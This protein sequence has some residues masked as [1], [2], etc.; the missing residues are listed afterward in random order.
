MQP[1]I[2]IALLLLPLLWKTRARVPML[3]CLI[4]FI[5][6]WIHMALAAG[7]TGA[8]HAILPWPLPAMF[9]AVAFAEASRHISFG[10]W[11]LGV[12]MIV[13]AVSGLLV[14][15][16]HLYQLAR[17]GAGDPW[18]DAIYPLAGGLKKTN[19]SRIM[20]I[21]WGLADSLVVIN[22]NNPPILLSDDPLWSEQYSADQKQGTANLLADRSTV[23]IEHVDGHE[24]MRGIN[25][26]VRE[27]A[28]RLGFEPSVFHTYND[29]NGRPIFQTLHFHPVQSCD[30]CPGGRQ[31]AHQ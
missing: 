9:V 30:A 2:F 25:Q 26:R 17:N 20:L 16:Q 18:T 12:T 28:R 5:V 22:G 31:Q 6:A 4:A 23:W 19:P 10:S 11:V 7:G 14:T 13:I 1:A 27:G 21:D 24:I 15:N 8:H 3:F 29:S